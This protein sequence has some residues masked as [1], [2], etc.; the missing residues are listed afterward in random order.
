MK[1][2]LYMIG[3]FLLALSNVVVAQQTIKGKVF[4]KQT[5]EP[6]IGAMITVPNTTVG[7][8]AD[9][10]GTFSLS[11][12]ADSLYVSFI[13]YDKTVVNIGNDKEL[14]VALNSSEANLQRLLLRQI[15]RQACEQK[16]L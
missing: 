6:L 2:Q 4:D 13:G 5:K 1:K 16:P 14:S 9:L 3:F 15:V 11:A 8:T 7:T 10:N 12:Q